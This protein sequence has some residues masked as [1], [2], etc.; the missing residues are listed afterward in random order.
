MKRI[1]AW[2]DT[3]MHAATKA[4]AALTGKYMA[5]WFAEAVAEKLARGRKIERPEEEK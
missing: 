5:Q 3:S 1:F 2:I 4:Q